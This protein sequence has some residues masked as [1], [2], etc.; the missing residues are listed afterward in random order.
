MS[1][2]CRNNPEITN[3]D[4]RAE[5]HSDA[6][7]DVP[8]SMLGRTACEVASVTLAVNAITRMAL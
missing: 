3:G 7:Y 5:S 1:E 2:T 6:T 4:S 8:L